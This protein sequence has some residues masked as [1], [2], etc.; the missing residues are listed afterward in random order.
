MTVRLIR[1]LV[2]IGVGAA[3]AHAV[4][5]CATVRPWEKEAL[6]D[7]IMSFD[8]DAREAAKE[9]HWMEAREGSTGGAGAAGGG[10]ACN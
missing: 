7:P 1:P 6:A 3:I 9:L 5:G 8:E 2:L 4:S 10:C